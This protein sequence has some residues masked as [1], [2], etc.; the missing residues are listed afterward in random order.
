MDWDWEADSNDLHVTHEGPHGTLCAGVFAA[1]TNNEVGVAGV[2][3]GDGTAGSGARILPAVVDVWTETQ[4]AQTMLWARQQGSV[5][6][7]TSIGLNYS[8]TMRAAIGDAWINGMLIFCSAGNL[9]NGLI[10]SP[11]CESD[12]VFC[13]GAAMHTGYRYWDCLTG[14]AGASS[15]HTEA[16]DGEIVIDGLAPGGEATVRSTLYDAT[17]TDSYASTFSG[18]SAAS[19]F[20]MGIAALVQSYVKT[21]YDSLLTPGRLMEVMRQSAHD[22][23]TDPDC[24]SDCEREMLGPDQYTGPGRLDAGRALTVPTIVLEYPNGGESLA[25]NA[26]VDIQWRAWDI[27]DNLSATESID[28]YYSSDAD[29]TNT[30]WSLVAGGLNTTTDNTLNT[31]AW[32]FPMRKRPETTGGSASKPPTQRTPSEST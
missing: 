17:A 20:A 24:P 31:Y 22:V 11:G 2:A 8:Q 29:T 4:M 1:R 32:T 3:G 7:S 30:T 6:Y 10:Q 12:S 13:V 18:T 23:Y 28:I 9:C 27:N 5:L 21:R 26:S 14:S 25:L 15:Y 16:D 19:P